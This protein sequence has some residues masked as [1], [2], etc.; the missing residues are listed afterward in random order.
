MASGLT[1][2]VSITGPGC[3]GKTTLAVALAAKL[4]A[5]GVA[6]CVLDLDCYFRA[7]AERDRAMPP[8][9]G[10]DP[11]GYEI[12]EARRDIGRLLGGETIHP[13]PYNKIDGTRGEPG[14]LAP[15]T[16]LIIEGS[17]ALRPDLLDVESLRLYIDAAPQTQF[18]NR[19]RREIGFGHSDATISA[20]Y[21]RL[22][23]DYH[24][25]IRPQ[26]RFAHLR[27]RVDGAYRVTR[28]AVADP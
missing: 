27:A 25:H 9:S 10:Y 28:I 6:A 20:K 2:I 12:G 8:I 19:R 14:A 15:A 4:E 23:P 16:A 21:R 24:L 13:R 3:T 1:P 17:M 22:L 11:A 7:R 26:R 18:E 5:R